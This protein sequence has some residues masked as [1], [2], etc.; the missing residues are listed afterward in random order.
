MKITTYLTWA[1]NLEWRHCLTSR[2]GTM[3]L[4][5]ITSIWM[6]SFM[7]CFGTISI[8][9]SAL[10][11]MCFLFAFFSCFVSFLEWGF[12]E[13]LLLFPYPSTCL[14]FLPLRLIVFALPT[15]PWISLFCPLFPPLLQRCRTL[16]F[17]FMKRRFGILPLSRN[18]SCML[19]RLENI[20]Y[21]KKKVTMKW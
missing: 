19:L 13:S 5:G 6:A 21:L 17:I 8:H 4:K 11:L 1:L 2:Y 12:I 18:N 7:A 14:T 16:R 20:F 3:D 9:L 15:T 10:P